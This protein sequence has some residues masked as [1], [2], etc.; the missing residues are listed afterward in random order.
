MSFRIWKFNGKA[1]D[2]F[3]ALAKVALADRLLEIKFGRCYTANIPHKNCS[4]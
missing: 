2:F 4:N 3:P 1:K